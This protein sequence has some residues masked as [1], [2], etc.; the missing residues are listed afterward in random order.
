MEHAEPVDDAVGEL[1][2]DDLAAQAMRVDRGGELLAHRRR[3]GGVEHRR[4]FVGLGRAS[5]LD[6]CLQRE[7]AVASSTA[8][9]GRVSPR[10]PAR[11][12]AG[13]RSLEPSTARSSR[14]GPR[15]SRS[16]GHS[17]AGAC[18]PSRSAMI[19][20]PSVWRRLSSSTR[21]ATSSVIEARKVLRSS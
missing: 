12:A 8:S 10:P 3:E 14:P 16:R 7:L 1:G 17:W 2:R 13:P 9:S 18:A 6:R 21:C 5:L 15:R 11:G 4:E 20:R 19:D